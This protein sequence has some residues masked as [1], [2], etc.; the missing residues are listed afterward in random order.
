MTTLEVL[1]CVFGGWVCSI[2][3]HAFRWMFLDISREACGFELML[4]AS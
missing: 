3:M 4:S 2:E 1:L